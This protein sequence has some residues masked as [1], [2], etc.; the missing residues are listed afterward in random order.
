MVR[1]TNKEAMMVINTAIGK[2]RINSPA[3]SVKKQEE[4]MLGSGCS[5]S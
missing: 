5:T 3:P 2:L 1:A 4:E